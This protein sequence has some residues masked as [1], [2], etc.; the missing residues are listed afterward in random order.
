MGDKGESLKYIRKALEINSNSREVILNC[1]RILIS[2]KESDEALKLY[3][4]YLINNPNDKEI[5][6]AFSSLSACDNERSLV[7]SLI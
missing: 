4:S 1:G 7:N 5:S 2:L 6:D 3:R